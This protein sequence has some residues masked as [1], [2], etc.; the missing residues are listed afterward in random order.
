MFERYLKERKNEL[1]LA[2]N[3]G[4]IV[5]KIQ[6][7]ICLITEIYTKPEL[8]KNKIASHLADKVF[9]IAKESSCTEVQCIVDITANDSEL[10][11]L[12][13]LHYGF[14]P[15]LCEENIIRFYKGVNHGE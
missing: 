10:S 6:E 9:E 7:K 5:Y 14:K 13:I 11:L 8:R 1:V 4:F 2:V 12:S 15:F 3:D